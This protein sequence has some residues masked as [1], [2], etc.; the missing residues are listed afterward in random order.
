MKLRTLLL[1]LFPL[2]SWSQEIPEPYWDEESG[3][4]GFEFEGKKIT[5]PIY[6][7]G[8]F[9]WRSYGLICSKENR[10]GIIN[11]DGKE[12]LEFIYDD[13][14]KFDRT[15]NRLFLV[16]D[17]LHGIF[18]YSLKQITPYYEIADEDQF[19]FDGD[20]F[21]WKDMLY[22]VKVKGKL[23][24]VDINGNTHVKPEYKFLQRVYFYTKQN[25][26]TYPIDALDKYEMEE[27]SYRYMVPEVKLTRRFLVNTKKG[28]TIIGENG[29]LLNP[30]I[31][32]TDFYGIYE[33]SWGAVLIEEEVKFVNF[34][35]G[36]VADQLPIEALDNE[37]MRDLKGDYGVLRKD[38]KLLV[39]FDAQ[40]IRYSNKPFE[41]FHVTDKR[42]IE[43]L[44]DTSGHFFLPQE[45]EGV[46]EICSWGTDKFYPI[47][48]TKTEDTW[49]IYTFS[50]KDY[51]FKPITEAIFDD[52]SCDKESKTI[53]LLKLDG[54]TGY[55]D[56]EG[57]IS[58]E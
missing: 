18:D 50:K 54:T 31:E 24:V 40:A 8:E 2:Y 32:F 1:L 22:D 10:F 45:Y 48:I 19:Q 28:Y 44:V 16:K 25:G 39:E 46:K 58:W 20:A 12:I 47:A 4:V 23:G 30:E 27:E 57:N 36:T 17:G 34:L 11:T 42:G 37:I 29:E 52:V 51:S 15:D 6:D 21:G 43:G 49:A 9:H 7:D 56:N 14:G 38:G 55:M 33:Q 53:R 13:I 26:N 5:D 3:L 35:D 41:F